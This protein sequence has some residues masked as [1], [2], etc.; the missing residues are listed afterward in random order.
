MVGINFLALSG[1][2]VFVGFLLA[3]WTLFWSAVAL[4]RAA[5]QKQKLWF[6]VLLL[7][8]L[9]GI[10]A[11]IYIFVVEKMEIGEWFH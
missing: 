4:W 10:P 7:F 5:N 3:A 1:G 2:M 11:L 6:F 8:P 9:W